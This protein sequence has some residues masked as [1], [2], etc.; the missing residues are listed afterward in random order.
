MK[1]RIIALA[2]APYKV[3]ILPSIISVYLLV[4]GL[5]LIIIRQN[6]LDGAL[7]LLLLTYFHE[8]KYYYLKYTVLKGII[9]LDL[10]RLLSNGRFNS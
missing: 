1:N 7:L 3:G 2:I 8:S 6:W 9:F 4:N 5:A 10:R